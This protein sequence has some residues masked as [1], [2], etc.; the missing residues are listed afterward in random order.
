MKGR[1]APPPLPAPR[2]LETP[3]ER[4]RRERE[5]FERVAAKVREYRGTDSARNPPRGDSADEQR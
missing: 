4:D 2:R 3:E 1:V 5:S